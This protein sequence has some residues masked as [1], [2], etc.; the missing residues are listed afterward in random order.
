M[1][2]TLVLVA[3][4]ILVYYASRPNKGANAIN[5]RGLPAG[6]VPTHRHKSIALDSAT[7]RLWVRD[8][9]GQERVLNPNEVVEWVTT[10]VVKNNIWGMC[11]NT[12]NYLEIRTFDLDQPVW[13]VR[14]KN[15]GET[16]PSNR[17]HRECTEWF[18]RLTAVYNHS[19]S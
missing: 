9:K 7:K 6:F 11:W 8:E 12:K 19:L 16:F 15:H 3:T 2:L 5:L 13:R 17:N 18:A 4:A 10:S 14:F 1:L